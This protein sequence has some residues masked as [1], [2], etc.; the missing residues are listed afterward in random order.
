M[1][2]LLIDSQIHSTKI[3]EG[4]LF[5]FERTLLILFSPEISITS[6]TTSENS[7][8]SVLFSILEGNETSKLIGFEHPLLPRYNAIV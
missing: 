4:G 5:G 1:D 3:P 8:N 7:D 6:D 2:S